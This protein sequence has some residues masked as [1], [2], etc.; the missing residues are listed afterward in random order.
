MSRRAPEAAPLVR[1][2]LP[3]FAPELERLLTLAGSPEL[4]AQVRELRLVGRCRCGQ[5]D[6]ATFHVVTARAA[7]PD[8]AFGRAE[9]ECADLEAEGGSVVVDVEGGRLRTV[10]VLGWPDV[11]AELDAA[12]PPGRG[13][14]P[15]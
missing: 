2:A 13:C 5:P 3:S 8:P 11:K 7:P 14:L 12:I 10:E 4:A 1:D 9:L 6:C 15:A